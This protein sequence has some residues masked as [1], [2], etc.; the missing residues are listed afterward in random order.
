MRGLFERPFGWRTVAAVSP[1]AFAA[2]VVWNQVLLTRL[3]QTAMVLPRAVPGRVIGAIGVALLLYHGI[4]VL[5]VSALSTTSARLFEGPDTHV[6]FRTIGLAMAAGHLP[7]ALWALNGWLRLHTLGPSA[8]LDALVNT[9]LAIGGSRT[10]AYIVAVLWTAVALSEISSI[11][12][13]RAA[14][15]LLPAAGTLIV[16][17]KLVDR[18]TTPL[19]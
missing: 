18:L 9:A 10:V 5:V 15:V 6:D 11:S 13:A 16:V 2:L 1:L 7:L 4:L 3:I 12:L 19:W 8:S 17:L 14:R